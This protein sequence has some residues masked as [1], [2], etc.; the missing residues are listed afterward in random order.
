MERRLPLKARY[1]TA[2]DLRASA[3]RRMPR[4][5]FEYMDGGADAAFVGK[6]FLWSLG[7]LGAE[8]PAHLI[9]ILTE[10]FRS[11]LGQLGCTSVDE[12]R[13]I[14]VRHP[15]EWQL[16]EFAARGRGGG[17]PIFLS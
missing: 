5:A 17:K 16:H 14:A 2:L 4:F 8:G 11:T 7:A 13:E 1:P 9:D 15:G 10:E 12:L 3:K 6:A